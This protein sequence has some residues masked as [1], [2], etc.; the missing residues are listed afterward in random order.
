[1]I[2][3]ATFFNKG[4][5]DALFNRPLPPS[6]G[7]GATQWQNLAKV[8]N[9]GFEASVDATIVRTDP[10]VFDIRLNGSV[11]K[12]ELTD[13]GGAPLPTAPGA[14][15]VEGFPLFG[16]WDRKLISYSDANSDGIITENEIVVS[17]TA[18]Y[19][20]PTLPERQ[21]GV[22]GSLGFFK[23]TLRLS[24][25][26][27]YR[28]NF[29]NQ[30]GYQ[31]QRCVSSGNC[32]AVNDPSAPLGD[33]AAA[34]A[35]NS[36]TKRTQ[37][38]LFVRNDFVRFREMSVAYTIPERLVARSRARSATVVLSGRNLGVP[39]TKYP[40][41]DPEA[42]SA[43]ANNLGGNNDFFS[44]PALRYWIVRVNLGI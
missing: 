40:G 32:R 30:W 6:F 31:N 1:V 7:A 19:R 38:G 37:W 2:V 43:V 36:A 27:D 10:V 21:A 33:Q 39:W 22:T 29:Y 4:S 26:F 8:R 34:V 35:A 14:R 3:E 23:N 44:P 12:N 17:D 15:N 28:G 11:I 41:I 20:G 16:L 13:A 5:K 18:L 25:L 24:A 42:N 9:R